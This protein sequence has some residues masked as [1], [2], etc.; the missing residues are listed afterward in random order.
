M[1]PDVVCLAHLIIKAAVCNR[2]RIGR[3]G[4]V[5][6]AALVIG[7][8]LVDQP[9][10]LQESG[11]HGFLTRPRK[12]I[13]NIRVEGATKML[14]RIKRDILVEVLD[15]HDGGLRH[16]DLAGEIPL[17]STPPLVADE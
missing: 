15:A 1:S 11:I 3:R 5:A 2:I 9:N 16:A 10:L 14:K 7:A 6:A 4:S 17:G 8:V 13:T 12:Q